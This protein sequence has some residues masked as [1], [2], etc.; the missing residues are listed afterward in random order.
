MPKPY[1]REFREDVIRVARNREP[2]RPHEGRRRRLRDLGVVPEQLA[3]AGRCRG[4]DQARPTEAENVEAVSCEARSGSSSRRTRC[5]AE[6]RR[7]C[8]R[9]TCREMMYPLV[10][11]LADDG[12]PVTVT[13]RVLKHR[14]PALLPV[15]AR[16]GDRPPAS[17]RPTWRTRSSTPTAMT[18]VR[19]PVPRR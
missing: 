10:R 15:V 14:P 3:Q 9:R 7:I 8:R 16:S 5:C 19:L 17:P 1:P 13:C 4:R 18:R 11:E 12:I 6:P 2:G